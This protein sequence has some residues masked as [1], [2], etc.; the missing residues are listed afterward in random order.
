[1]GRRRGIARR[2]TRMRAA[3]CAKTGGAGTRRARRFPRCA[4]A[5]IPHP[6]LQRV[7][8]ACNISISIP[9]FGVYIAVCCWF[10][11]GR[12]SLSMVRH[13]RGFYT[14]TDALLPAS[15]PPFDRFAPPALS[16]A[17]LPVT[18][19]RA[20]ARLCHQPYVRARSAGDNAQRFGLAE[21][22]TE[23]GSSGDS[24]V[25]RP[26]RNMDRRPAR[27]AHLV[28]ATAA[29]CHACPHATCAFVRFH[30]VWAGRARGRRHPRSLVPLPTMRLVV[31]VAVR[32][33]PRAH[34]PLHA[35]L[36]TLPLPH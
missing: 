5:A 22:D 15:I 10:V 18:T 9:L 2:V 27:G 11:A 30:L 23:R 26:P 25:R 14:R 36:P 7:L 8:D 21:N 32:R 24:R 16:P 31:L 17:C 4:P 28:V 3:A 19:L 12:Y 1:M 13:N 29:S 33:A 6:R 20:A 35:V 34:T